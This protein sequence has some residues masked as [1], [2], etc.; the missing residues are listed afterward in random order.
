[1]EEIGLEPEGWAQTDRVL[2]LKTTVGG[3]HLKAKLRI[4]LLTPLE[5]DALNLIRPRECITI[6][7]PIDEQSE[8]AA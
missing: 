3:M 4:H 1:M 7:L 2:R 8:I 6:R 5:T